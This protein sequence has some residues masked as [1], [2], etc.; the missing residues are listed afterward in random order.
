MLRLPA[1][2]VRFP[3]LPVLPTRAPA[4]MPELNW[5]VGPGPVIDSAPAASTTT[6]PPFPAPVAI[7]PMPLSTE[8]LV[9]N[10]MSIV[11]GPPTLTERFP[12]LPAPEAV[13]PREAPEA[14]V[15]APLTDTAIAP[16]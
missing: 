9:P 14:T 10:V 5:A 12:A 3:A 16:P 2:T 7:E 1:D 11:S 8:V 6:L 4:W 15:A 13:V